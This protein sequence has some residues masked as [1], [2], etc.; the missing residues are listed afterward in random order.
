MKGK[1]F[2]ITSQ[3]IKYVTIDFVAVS[4]AFFLFNVFRYYSLGI[5]TYG[6][7]SIELYLLN[8][9]MIT[10][11]I[12]IPIGMLG[13]FWLSGYYN[14]VIGKS[15]VAELSTTILSIL[16]ATIVIYLLLLIND[17]NGM[18]IRDYE[19][20]FTLFSLFLIQTYTGRWVITSNT[21]R[22]LKRRKWIYSTLIIGNSKVS[23]K[24]YRKLKHSGSVWAF[25]VIGF[26]RIDKEHDVDDSFTVWEWKEV[27]QV[28]RD[29]SVD[30]IVLA[31]EHTRDSGIMKIL[32][33]LF[34]LGIPVK[35]APDV[36][37]FITG[38]IRLNDILGIPFIDLTSPRM[39]EFEKN[40]KRTFDVVA[41]LLS[42]LLLSPVYAITALMVKFTSEG[43]VIFKQ[44][45]MGKGHKPFKIL[46]F[47][48]MYQNAE[49]EGPRLSSTH[50]SRITRFGKFMRKYRIDELP[51]FWN[52]LKGDM[53]LVGPRPEREYYIEQIMR[54]APYYGLVF[55]VKPGITSWGMVKYGYA[56]SV[57]QMV[58][59]SKYDLI[60]INNMSIPNDIKIMIYT[61]RTIV[62]GS[63]L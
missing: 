63:G 56:S 25:D 5:Q 60:Y 1:N 2:S 9:K 53:S 46:K 32:E 31:L 19:M 40:L 55:Q 20:I 36:L 7:S 14:K 45:R 39:N 42:M 52:V 26:V 43:P 17:S 47:R 44:E 4:V 22:L 41:S 59:R 54:K 16:F 50:D 28:C 8:P 15:R 13:I 48:S 37:S 3:R 33:R 27:E 6:Y 30:Q 61:I 23:R 34:P 51:Q 10:E 58:E 29:Y 35:I 62:K 24:I 21:I 12:L 57:N 49:K 18:K 11:Q 38:N